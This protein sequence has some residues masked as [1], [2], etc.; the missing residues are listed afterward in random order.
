M[1]VVSHTLYQAIQREI[2]R[3]RQ[4]VIDDEVEVKR[5][6]QVL[7]DAI[8]RKAMHQGNLDNLL[9]DAAA[10]GIPVDQGLGTVNAESY[11]PPP[12]VVKVNAE[13]YKPPPPRV[14]KDNPQ[15]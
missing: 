3:Q 2:K 15:A 7:N 8:D 1:T 14:I 5:V 6:Q 13:S 4:Y 10:L 11:E 12:R 9:K